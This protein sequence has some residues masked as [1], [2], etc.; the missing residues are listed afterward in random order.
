MEQASNSKRL[1]YKHI[2]EPTH[3]ILRYIDNRRKGVNKSLKTRWS[4]FNRQCMGG[5]EPNTIYTIAGI[6]GSGKS[7]F[8]NSL[9]TDLFD[10]N[11]NKQFVVLSFNFEML[12]SRQVGRKLSYRM[13]KTTS[14]LYSAHL[15][16]TRQSLSDEEYNVALKHAERIQQYPIYYVDS[17]GTVDEIDLT[18][19]YFQTTFSDKW[20]IV[21]LDHTLLTKSRIGEKERETLYEIQKVFM[22]AK[23]VGETTIIQISQM[24]REIEGNDRIVNATMHYPMRRDIFG[25]DSVFQASDYVI[26]IHRPEILGIDKYGPSKEPVENMIFMHFLKVREGEPK[27]IKFVNNLKF[28]SID[29]FNPFNLNKEDKL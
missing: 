23:K 18:I 6:S 13:R 2:S 20:L 9:E 27:I 24:N 25:G 28:N 14:D 19:Q 1:S 10:L 4:K 16:E 8:V 15:E 12:A 3:E 7:S 21:I 5:I 11:P 26:V 22:Q 17:P 29:E